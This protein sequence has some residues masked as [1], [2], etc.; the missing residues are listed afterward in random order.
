MTLYRKTLSLIHLNSGS[1]CTNM[2]EKVA[3]ESSYLGIFDGQ[4]NALLSHIMVELR[5]GIF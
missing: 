1:L 5:N 2:N 3:I 4:V